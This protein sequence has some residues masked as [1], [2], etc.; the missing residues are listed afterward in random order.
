MDEILIDKEQLKKQQDQM[1]EL[2]HLVSHDL[3]EPLRMIGMYTQ[4]LERRLGDERLNE[5]E[6]VFMKYVKEGVTRMQ[7][8][9]DGMT[10]LATAGT[11]K[12]PIQNTDI[13]DVIYYVQQN[14]KVLINESNAQIKIMGI[15][16][17]AHVRYSDMVHL[18]QNIIENALKFRRQNV[19]CEI[20]I[21]AKKIGNQVK[22]IIEDNGQGLDKYMAERIF[23]PFQRAS[24]E[25]PGTGI[26]LAI[27]KKIVESYGGQICVESKIDKGST[28][29]FTFPAEKEEI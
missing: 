8:M 6:K 23:D 9:I 18:F 16:P 13:T 10:S 11:S 5:D 22:Y 4:L 20:H 3:K 19:R 1:H 2:M 24:Q 26:G 25:V 27:C 14:L 28:F 15:L 7:L 21:F 29:S 17:N 12:E